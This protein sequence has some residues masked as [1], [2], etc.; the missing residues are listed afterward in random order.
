M[1]LTRLVALSLIVGSPQARAASGSGT[2]REYEGI[3]GA[4]TEISLIEREEEQ[5]WYPR[6]ERNFRV[7]RSRPGFAGPSR[8]GGPEGP[9]RST[10]GR[11]E[12][13][14]QLLLR[15]TEQL[16]ENRARGRGQAPREAVREGRR[17]QGMPPARRPIA[18]ILPTRRPPETGARGNV[19]L[20]RAPSEQLRHYYA[21]G[22]HLGPDVIPVDEA[23]LEVYLDVPQRGLGHLQ[24]GRVR[25]LRIVE[26]PVPPPAH[27]L[28]FS[29]EEDWG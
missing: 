19:Q 26:R 5:F 9:A 25:L 2:G 29:T 15:L 3:M 7:P 27:T 10:Q 16:S 8:R 4:F 1:L 11:G 23:P 22:G 24:R 13:R 18:V 17:T 12:T 21:L 20:L 14:G 6:E 28:F